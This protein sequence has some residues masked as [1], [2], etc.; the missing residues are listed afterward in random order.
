MTLQIKS[1]RLSAGNY[2]IAC[3]G[4]IVS[5]R[6]VDANKAYGDTHDMWISAALWNTGVYTDPVET[7]REAIHH[8][9]RMLREIIATHPNTH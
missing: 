1:N 6:R 5:V 7:K 2:E 9:K 4:Y 8:A 3:G